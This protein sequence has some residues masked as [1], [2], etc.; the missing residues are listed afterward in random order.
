MPESHYCFMHVGPQLCYSRCT[1]YTHVAWRDT[2]PAMQTTRTLNCSR[3]LPCKSS[4]NDNRD[5]LKLTSFAF[6]LGPSVPH[7]HRGR[8]MFLSGGATCAGNLK[9]IQ[10]VK[11]DIKMPAVKQKWN[12]RNISDGRPWILL[13]I[14]LLLE[15]VFIS[16]FFPRTVLVK[17]FHETKQGYIIINP[18]IILTAYTTVFWM[19]ESKGPTHLY[20]TV[21]DLDFLLTWK[22]KFWI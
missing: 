16:A 12:R 13:E 15:R 19:F 2:K 20:Q 17:R 3:P 10:Q 18:C 11:L 5:I 9:S 22:F 14:L 6:D 21:L 4:E 8:S 7:D 1:L